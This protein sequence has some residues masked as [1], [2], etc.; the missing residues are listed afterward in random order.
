MP[1][2]MSSCSG[3]MRSRWPRGVRHVARAASIVRHCSSSRSMSASACCARHAVLEPADEIQEVAAARVREVRRVD[4]QRPPDLDL[5]VVHVVAARHDADDLLGRVVDL[6]VLCRRC[7]R[8]RR[9]PAAR[10]P[11]DRIA[12]GGAL[13]TE[14]SAVNQRPRS[15]CTPSVGISSGVTSALTGRLGGVRVEVHG[16]DR[17]GADRGERLVVVAELDELRQSRP[18]TG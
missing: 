18:R 8:R 1:P 9:T 14:S 4:R 15:G 10:V 3:S 7:R 13:G 11:Y 5:R 2:T 6:D 16:A 12:T 17:V